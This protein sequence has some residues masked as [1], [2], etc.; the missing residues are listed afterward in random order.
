MYKHT[1]DFCI[2]ILYPETLNSFTSS[3]HFFSG[4]LRFSIYKVVL[5]LPLELRCL[6][7]LFSY[8]NVL[9]VISSIRLNVSGKSRYLLSY[10]CSYGES[11]QSFSIKYGIRCGIFIANLFQV[12]ELPFSSYLL[13]VFKIILN[14]CIFFKCFS[15][16]NDHVVFVH[17]FIGINL[18]AKTTFHSW[19]KS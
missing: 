17:C 8:L 14:C 15:A 5:L 16:S 6:L 10:S 19:N 2:W 4:F 7:F 18:S 3:N 9:T 11:I 1:I 13:S 12:E